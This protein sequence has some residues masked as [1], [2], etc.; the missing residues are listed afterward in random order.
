MHQKIKKQMQNK[1]TNE[2]IYTEAHDIITTLNIAD[3]S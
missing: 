1:H 3:L 2:H